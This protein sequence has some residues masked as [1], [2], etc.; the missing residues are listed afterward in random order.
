MPRE[1]ARLLF[2]INSLPPYGAEMFI[3]NHAHHV[4]RDR[5]EVAVCQL[6]GSDALAPRFHE[7]GI[8]VLNCH[9]RYRFDPAALARLG[10]VLRHRRID[11]LQTHVGYAGVVGRIVGRAVGVRA[12]VSTEQTVRSDYGRVIRTANDL[13]FRWAHTNVFISRAVLGSFAE[14][15][16]ELYS[17]PQA[18]IT[19]GIDTRA[20]AETA[21]AGRAQAR[22]EL[23]M[24]A[25][26]LAFGNVAR[27][28]PTKGQETAIRALARVRRALPRASLWIIG[29]GP[30]EDHLL[31]VARAEGVSD[32]VHL[33]GQSLD[34]PRLLG[35]FDAYVHPANTEGLGISVLEAMAAGLP[36]IASAVD[37]LPEFVRD[38]DTGWLVPPRDPERLAQAMVDVGRDLDGARVVAERGRALVQREHDIRVS[39]AAYERIYRRLLGEGSRPMAEAA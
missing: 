24:A 32:A 35:A 26:E 30:L 2:L 33:V 16:P 37:G 13:T 28:A 4:D 23:G 25:D 15:F 8:E 20:L 19:N 6:G 27:L 31:G 38:G 39:V 10:L 5:Y 9:A 22:A 1:R 36:T 29:A 7:A 34:V 11:I 18:V 3:L 14:V 12:I 21:A 17:E